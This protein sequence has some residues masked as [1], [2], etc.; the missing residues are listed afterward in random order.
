MQAQGS[1]VAAVGTYVINRAG[2]D[3]LALWPPDVMDEIMV[4][5]L[6]TESHATLA[7]VRPTVSSREVL[8]ANL[9][10]QFRPLYAREQE[11]LEAYLDNARLA[12][13]V[14][15]SGPWEIKV[16]LGCREVVNQAGVHR[17]LDSSNR[18][19]YPEHHRTIMVG[20]IETL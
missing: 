3:S 19:F 10:A 17:C 2:D 20:P 18:T 4:V 13:R 12:E 5:R 14:R 16:C 15:P 7:G 11:A 8:L 9:D 6:I 1:T